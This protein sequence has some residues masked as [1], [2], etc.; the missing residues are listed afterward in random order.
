MCDVSRRSRAS[1]GLHQQRSIALS[2]GSSELYK[3]LLGRHK[4]I[5]VRSP[6]NFPWMSRP[7][8]T[9]SLKSYEGPASSQTRF[10][11]HSRLI[12]CKNS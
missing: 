1:R 5:T 7:S 10:C 9:E 8:Q 12:H 3:A 4:G 6:I 11:R 2:L